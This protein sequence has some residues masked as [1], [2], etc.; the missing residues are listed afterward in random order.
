[1]SSTRLVAGR[2]RGRTSAEFTFYCLIENYTLSGKENA[3]GSSQQVSCLFPVSHAVHLPARPVDRSQAIDRV[4]VRVCQ[5][6]G[7]EQLSRTR[8][9]S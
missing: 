5:R 9:N 7:A 3:L 8:P 6:P 4:D 2:I 1:M